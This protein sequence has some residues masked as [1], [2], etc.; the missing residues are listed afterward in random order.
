MKLTNK[1][2]QLSFLFLLAAG[3]TYAVKG[4]AESRSSGI[5]D[6]KEVLL[7]VAKLMETGQVTR[8]HCSYAPCEMDFRTDSVPVGRKFERASIAEIHSDENGNAIFN[9]T[10]KVGMQPVSVTL[11]LSKEKCFIEAAVVVD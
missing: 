10:G 5:Y 9:V 8:S 7:C 2:L 4:S 6:K 3:C 1:I 11:S